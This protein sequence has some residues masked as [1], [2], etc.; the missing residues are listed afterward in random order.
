M[1]DHS[2]CVCEVCSRIMRSRTPLCDLRPQCAF[3]GCV[4]VNLRPLCR[5]RLFE[6]D[7]APFPAPDFCNT[8]LCICH[9]LCLFSL[10]ATWP[11]AA[12]RSAVGHRV[13]PS[14]KYIVRIMHALA[15]SV[16]ARTPSRWA[17][18]FL[19]LWIAQ[20][21]VSSYLLMCSSRPMILRNVG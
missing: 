11:A 13:A 10:F 9:C 14:A 16:T 12:C 4:G 7:G 18:S 19:C 5:P 1:S 6:T 15:Q 20:R 3:N 17:E 2:V 21:L 8:P